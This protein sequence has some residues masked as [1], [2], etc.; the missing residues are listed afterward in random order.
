LELG[1]LRFKGDKEKIKSKIKEM[2]DLFPILRERENVDAGRLSGG[3]QRMLE[4][5]RAL[6]SEPKMLILDEPSLGLAPKM[7]KLLFDKIK[8]V[9]E[10]LHVTI[11]LAEQ[12]VRAALENSHYAYVIDLG[13]NRVEG[14]SKSLLKDKSLAKY[15]LG[16]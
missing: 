5:A 11:L 4:I 2:Y 12:N 8:E 16:T 3:E 6:M 10:K 7:V 9:N 14:T 13:R 1:G 15:I